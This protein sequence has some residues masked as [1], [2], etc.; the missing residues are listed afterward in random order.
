MWRAAQ[1]VRAWPAAPVGPGRVVAMAR[2]A[3]LR[4]LTVLPAWQGLLA[5]SVP[6][7]LPVLRVRPGLRVA[8]ASLL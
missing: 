8:L 1:V 3:A 5:A 4:V 2:R 7:V 6:M